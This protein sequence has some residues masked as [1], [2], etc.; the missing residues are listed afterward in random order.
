MTMYIVVIRWIDWKKSCRTWSG[1]AKNSVSVVRARDQYK[2]I[3]NALSTFR[4][5][6]AYTAMQKNRKVEVES[7]K[8]NGSY[9][10]KDV[11]AVNVYESDWRESE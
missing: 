10:W 2:A 8:L 4:C 6:T 11:H 9:R 3:E 7:I 5:D 1:I